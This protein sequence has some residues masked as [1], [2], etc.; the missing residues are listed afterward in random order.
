[1][2]RI[3]ISFLEEIEDSIKAF[4]NYLTF[5]EECFGGSD[6]SLEFKF[7]FTPLINV[8]LV[9]NKTDWIAKF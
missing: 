1:M 3:F 8:S 5:K 6:L 4:R 9:N 7:C 2:R